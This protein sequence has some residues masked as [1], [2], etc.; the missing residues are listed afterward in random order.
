MS[1]LRGIKND[2]T[3]REWYITI[4]LCADS[5]PRLVVGMLSETRHAQKLSEAI[6]RPDWTRREL[7]NDLPARVLYCSKTEAPCSRKNCIVV[8]LNFRLMQ[9]GYARRASRDFASR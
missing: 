4:L 2:K 3:V 8:N 6:L 1:R 9:I 7:L 5:G